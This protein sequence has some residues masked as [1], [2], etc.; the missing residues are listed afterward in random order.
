MDP[1]LPSSSEADSQSVSTADGVPDPTALA[2]DFRVRPTVKVPQPRGRGRSSTRRL[3]LKLGISTPGGLVATVGAN[4]VLLVRYSLSV[5][6]LDA[7]DTACAACENLHGRFGFLTHLDAGVPLP[8]GNAVQRRMETLQARHTSSFSAAAVVFRGSGF[9]ATMVR[10]HVTAVNMASRT[11]HPSR[12]FAE[13]EDG[14]T[15]MLGYDASASS[16]A[17]GVAQSGIPQAD[18]Q[19]VSDMTSAISLLQSSWQRQ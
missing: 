13:L 19:V 7:L 1:L 4:V 9:E 3:S 11:R 17:A 18:P 8:I 10:S 6:C 5:E 15:W 2:E 16:S 12:V 14:I